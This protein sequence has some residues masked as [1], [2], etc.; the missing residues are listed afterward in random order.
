MAKT[1]TSTDKANM[2]NNFFSRCFNHA[3]PPLSPEFLHPA[4]TEAVDPELLSDLLCSEDEI[5]GY[6]LA[7]DTNKASGADGISAKMLRE[8]AHSIT[9][10]V[11]KLFN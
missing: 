11:T 1:S 8:T 6:L 3:L 2:L 10:A 5:C 9:P 7:L 4:D